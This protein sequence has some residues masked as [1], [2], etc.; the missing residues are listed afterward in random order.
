MISALGIGA[1][2]APEIVFGLIFRILEIVF[3][4]ARCLPDIHYCVG[5][6]FLRNHVAH[7]AVHQRDFAQVR[8]LDNTTS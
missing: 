6:W 4:I 7:S 2:F 5:D 8:I 3:A 1:K